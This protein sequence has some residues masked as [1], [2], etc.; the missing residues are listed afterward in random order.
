MENANKHPYKKYWYVIRTIQLFI[1]IAL[2]A[3]FI[4][5]FFYIPSKTYDTNE[6][7]IL[8]TH[9]D[10]QDASDSETNDLKELKLSHTNTSYDLTHIFLF[11]IYSVTFVV[12]IVIFFKD[13][14]GIR[15]AKLYELNSIKEKILSD[16]F[17]DSIDETEEIDSNTPEKSV[18]N[19]TSNRTALLKHYMDCVTEI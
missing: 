4:V 10:I 19:K 2:T 7:T 15:Y 13:D 14:S 16:D 3:P 8:T 11:M 1:L 18:T 6:T 17:I 9:Y 12:F 5:A